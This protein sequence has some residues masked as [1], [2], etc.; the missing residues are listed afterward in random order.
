MTD[1]LQL[2]VGQGYQYNKNDAYQFGAQSFDVSHRPR[3]QLVEPTLDVRDRL[4]R[5]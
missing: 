3:A 2:S 4:G 1:A 5:A